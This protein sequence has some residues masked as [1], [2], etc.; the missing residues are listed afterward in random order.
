[1]RPSKGQAFCLVV[2][3]ILQSEQFPALATKAPASGFL[4]AAPNNHD[5]LF[6]WQVAG[7]W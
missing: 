5:P 2:K 4:I 1:M 6:L 7:T 3:L